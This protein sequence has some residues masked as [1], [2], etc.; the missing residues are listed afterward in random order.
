[1]NVVS[2]TKKEV[3]D[4]RKISYTVKDA[5]QEGK[6][7]L[8]G[9]GEPWYSLNERRWSRP[10]LD[11]NGIVSGYIEEGSKTI[12]P[13][14]ASAKISMRLVPNQH[15]DK[16][17]HDFVKFIRTLTP[18]GAKVTVMKHAGALPYKAPTDHPVFDLIKKS[19]HQHF[20]R[21]PIFT[22]VGGSIGFIP[23]IAQ[24]LKV[25]V[26][27]IGFGLPDSNLHSPN[28]HL[29]LDN[30]FKGIATMTDFYHSLANLD[31]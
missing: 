29:I 24:V 27:M 31:T 23:I 16:I 15:P 4:Y 21:E 20:G 6:L 10:T 5:L 30:Y 7:L 3:R 28:E 25:P 26:I 11:V 12:I 14:K 1:D 17:F 19:L 22:G 8:I 9:G 18:K 2:P 13:A